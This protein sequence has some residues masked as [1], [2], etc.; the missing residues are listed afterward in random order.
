MVTRVSTLVAEYV[1][2]RTSNTYQVVREFAP[3]VTPPAA[4]RMATIGERRLG[5]LL[6]RVSVAR[7]GAPVVGTSRR[8]NR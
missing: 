3:E 4:D 8:A 1:Y 2:D 6:R 7:K 5:E